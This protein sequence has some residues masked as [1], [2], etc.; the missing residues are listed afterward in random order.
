[1]C[2]SLDI[3][4]LRLGHRKIV[5]VLCWPSASSANLVQAA[6]CADPLR[7]RPP[8]DAST[9]P[10]IACK[11]WG[12]SYCLLSPDR[13]LHIWSPIAFSGSVAPKAAIPN[14][15]TRPEQS[16]FWSASIADDERTREVGPSSSSYE[17]GEQGGAIRRGAGGAKG[18]DQGEC[19][20]ATLGPDAE[21]G[22][23]VTGA[24]AH[25]SNRGP[26]F[27]SRIVAHRRVDRRRS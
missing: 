23:R 2:S 1:M 18:W 20:P 27:I 15:R 8:P 6:A 25:T 21:P 11:L 22:N 17:A 12:H 9:L 3:V 26:S 13:H 5:S 16:R 19:K 24:G 14:G 4:P 10:P 7:V